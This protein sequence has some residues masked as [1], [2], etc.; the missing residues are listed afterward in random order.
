VRLL[1]RIVFVLFLAA[2]LAAVLLVASLTHS[3]KGFAAPVYL[4]LEK[5]MPTREFAGRLVDSGVI[6]YQWQFL[7]ARTLRPR[8]VLQA[9]EYEFKEP[10][11]VFQVFDR[12]AKGDVFVYPL[13]VPEGSNIFDIA[14]LLNNA[15]MKR[16]GDFLRAATDPR[17]IQ[18]LD[19]KAPSLEGYLF[20]STYSVNHLTTGAQLCREMTGEFRKEWKRLTAGRTADAHE[21]VTLASLVEKEAAVP[22]D[23]PLIASVFFNRLRKPMRLECDPTTIYAAQLE[24]RYRGTIYRSDLA[25]QNSYNTYQ[26]EGLPPGP[27]A[28]PGLDSLKAVLNPAQTDYLYF[29]AKP[30]GSGAH[31]F[32]RTLAEH[33]QAV[34]SY[35]HGQAK[36]V[37]TR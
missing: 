20:P 16:A 15:G 10:A 17:T 8:R 23:R 18:D 2:A 36:A 29:V 32:S 12:I 33:R 9:G 24:Q 21:V 25:N 6:H 7:L 26:H 3:Y 19:P 5:G 35:R 14:A 1:L 31:K 27:I 37:E 22:A 13:T 34:R 11:S 30:D 4:V 28:N